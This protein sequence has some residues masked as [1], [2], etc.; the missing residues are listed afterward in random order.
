M[1][2]SFQIMPKT[3]LFNRDEVLDKCIQLFHEKGYNATSMQDLVDATGLNRSSLYNSFGSKMNIFQES[4]KVY[5]AKSAD[6]VHSCL[7]DSKTPKSALEAIF[8]F[9]VSDTKNGCLL[10][11]CTTEMANQ[12]YQLKRFLES[13]ST[14]MESIFERIVNKGQL[15]GSMN[16]KRTA[17]E[18][19]T[20]LFSSLQG[21]RITGMLDNDINKLK[22]IVKTTL[23]ILN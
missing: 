16:Y 21:L 8:L 4:L 13:N 5:K 22:G 12:D 19:A 2:H 15:E 6:M 7:L 9:A 18:Y 1:N 20:Y 23:S 17:K 14:E 11:N 10:S 3:E